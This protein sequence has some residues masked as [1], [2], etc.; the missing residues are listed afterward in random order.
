MGDVLKEYLKDYWGIVCDLCGEVEK[1][2]GSHEEAI[3]AAEEHLAGHKLLNATVT[4]TEVRYLDT[5][6]EEAK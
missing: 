1:R 5:Y 6:P 4:I 3:E 2:N